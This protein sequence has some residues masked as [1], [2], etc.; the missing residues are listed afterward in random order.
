LGA[1]PP[2]RKLGTIDCD[3]V[4]T[5]PVVFNG[6]LFRFE[7][8]RQNYR[9]NRSGSSYFRFIDVGSAT[10][11]PGFAVGHHFGSA[12]VE[13]GTVFAYGVEVQGGPRLTVFWS[14]DMRSW[15]SQAALDNPEWGIYNNSVCKAGDRY[16]MAVEL[17]KP[18]EEVGRP[19][20][21]RF[22]ESDDLLNWRLTPRECVFAK[23]RYT[24]CPALRFLDGYHYMIYLEERPGPTYEPHI[25]R[26]QDLIS[27]ESSPLN[28]MMQ[29]SDEDRKIAN[30]K[31]T[32][33]QREIIAEAVNINNSD[34]DLCEYG[35]RTV[36][37]YSW[38]NQHGVEF[39]AEAVYEGTLGGLMRGFFPTDLAG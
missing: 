23:D 13:G 9:P 19:F 27:W 38:G 31:L 37:Y 12:F 22:A 28:P 15:A 20:T 11:T 39:L 35:A 5:T 8:V 1:R 3:M 26:S 21:I 33:E 30:S 7:Y 24:A 10:P 18:A 2:I 29:F 32:A 17:S 4:E 6:R 25:V 36:I 16:L 14:D 34:V